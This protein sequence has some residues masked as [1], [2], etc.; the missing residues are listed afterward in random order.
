MD[1]AIRLRTTDPGQ[2]QQAAAALAG[3]F[4]PGD[5]VVLSGEL[6]AGKTCFVQGAA[7]ALGVEG[8]VTSPT[9]TL[10]RTYP[11]ARIPVVHCD[12]YRLNRLHDVFDLGD[13]VFAPDVVTFV[14]WGDAIGPLLPP[15]R[16]EVDIVLE[17]P[18]RDEGSRLVHLRGHGRWRGLRE[19][20]VERCSDWIV[21]E[22]AGC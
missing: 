7:G 15:D 20:I 5:V 3:L 18:T 4:E 17:D 6:G 21:E 14:E 13:E 22:E 1:E 10:V 12:V 9:F 16:L 11:T 19:H 2:T 8:R